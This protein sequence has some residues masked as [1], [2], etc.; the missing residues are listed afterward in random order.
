MKIANGVWSILG[1]LVFF[2]IEKIFPDEPET[3]ETALVSFNKKTNKTRSKTKSKSTQ[4]ALQTKS[5][6]FVVLHSFK[7]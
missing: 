7:V 5:R 2:S 1:I 3:S 4:R 6:K